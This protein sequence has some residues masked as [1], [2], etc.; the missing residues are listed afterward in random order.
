[1][2]RPTSVTVFAILNILYGLLYFCSGVFGIVS[3]VAMLV[4]IQ[5][6]SEF[7]DLMGPNAGMFTDPL[8]FGYSIVMQGIG[9]VLGMLAFVSAIGLL[10]MRHWA[11]RLTTVFAI[12]LLVMFGIGIISQVVMY[13]SGFN[14]LA[15]LDQFPGLNTDLIMIVSIVGGIIFN[16]VFTVLYPILMMYFLRR[17]HVVEAFRLANWDATVEAEEAS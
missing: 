4:A 17:P 7:A 1:M 8:F 12:S 14:P 2:G 13:A 11:R 16:A 15:S 10:M 6:E 5:A 3:S 9:I